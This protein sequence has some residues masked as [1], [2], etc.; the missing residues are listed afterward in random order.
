[1]KN[2]TLKF[3]KY[4][5]QQFLSTPTSYQNWLM[6]QDW[7]KI[8]QESVAKYDVVKKFTTDY[9]MGMGRSKEIVEYNL[10][11]DNAVIQKDMMNMYHLDETIECFYIES[12]R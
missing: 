2:F 4:K 1:M 10:T 9:R 6:Q 8:P 3:G 7:F 12:S 5:G 11:W